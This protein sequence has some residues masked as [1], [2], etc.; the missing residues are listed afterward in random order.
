MSERVISES[1]HIVKSKFT[2][3]TR[4]SDRH[5]TCVPT[6][7]YQVKYGNEMNLFL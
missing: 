7:F 2:N 1:K 3:L 6:D 5:K 4:S